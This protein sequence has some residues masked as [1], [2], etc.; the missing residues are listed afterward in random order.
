[1]RKTNYSERQ[2]LAILKEEAD[3]AGAEWCPKHGISAA[4]YY[5]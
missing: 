4:T 3:L 1:M 2:F 5:A